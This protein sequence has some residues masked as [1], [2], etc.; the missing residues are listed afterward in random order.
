MSR[1]GIFL[2]RRAAAGLFTVWAMITVAFLVF[3]AV[4]SEP[5]NFVYPGRQH[6]TNGQIAQAHHLLG[7]DH[8]KIVL[9]A[10]YVWRLLHGDFGHSWASYAQ[11]PGQSPFL[12]GT[13]KLALP[14]LWPQLSAELGVT[15]SIMLG[16]AAAVL[17]LAV[18]LGAIAG[19]LSESLGDRTISLLAL[20]G[21]CTH[22]MVVG[23]ILRS[24]FGDNL[25]WAPAGGYCPLNG[26]FSASG[27]GGLFV[28]GSGSSGPPVCNGPVD[29]AS[30]LVLP[31]ITFA[32]LFLALYTRMVRASVIETLPED[33]VR[34]AR[35]KGAGELRTMLRHVLPNA[36]LRVLT[37]IGMEIGTVIGV[38]VYIETAFSMNGLGR[39]GVFAM[40]GFDLPLLLGVVALISIIV[41]L[42]NLIV[43]A[44]YVVLDPRVRL[45]FDRSLQPKS[46]AGG[47][48]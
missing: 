30:H 12:P 43:D 46:L 10:H 14:G 17:L 20:I 21:V 28:P 19:R 16:G 44:C 45:S 5:A 27:G 42:G 24:L 11:F 34:T 41:V 2:V 18:P 48:I 26:G 23:L 7:I 22:P 40:I 32:L 35:A 1:V 47:V 4:P 38:S 29:W 13:H 37:M 6:L 33:F 39:E 36:A 25:H 31:W 8:S 9:Y 3:W 15:L